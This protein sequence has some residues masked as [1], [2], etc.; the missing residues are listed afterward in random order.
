MQ[1]VQINY[2]KE[3]HNKNSSPWVRMTHKASLEDSVVAYCQYYNHKCLIQTICKQHG[4]GLK[5]KNLKTKYEWA[6]LYHIVWLY[7]IIYE[8]LNHFIHGLI[9]K[10]EVFCC[11]FHILNTVL[12]VTLYHNTV[13]DFIS[14]YTCHVVVFSYS[15]GQGRINHM[16]KCPRAHDL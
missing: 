3:A 5:N 9:I 7:I 8:A 11:I 4:E 10:Y 15:P 14:H 13:C 16:G 1:S 2:I 12:N 6:V